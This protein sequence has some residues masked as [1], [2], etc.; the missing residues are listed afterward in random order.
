MISA[1]IQTTLEVILP[2]TFFAIGDEGIE[3]PFCVHNEQELP[4]LLLKE[5]VAGY[6]FMVE[7]MIIDTLPDTVAAK[8]ALVRAAIEA[9]AGTTVDSTKFETVNYEGDDPGFDQESRLY[10]NNM[11]FEIGTENR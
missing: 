11:R 3:A 7:I 6:N 5:G 4:P 8:V 2:D 9:L 10:G 1:A